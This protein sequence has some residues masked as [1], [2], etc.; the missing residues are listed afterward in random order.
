MKYFLVFLSSFFLLSVS[1]GAERKV[2]NKINFDWLC[3]CSQQNEL[4]TEFIV[5]ADEAQFLY[6]AQAKALSLCTDLNTKANK[7]NC[8]KLHSPF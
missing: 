3:E 5:T 1:Q 6:Q 2:K 7:V 4:F 8:Q